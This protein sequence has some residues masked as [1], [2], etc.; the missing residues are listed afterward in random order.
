M[1]EDLT[2][3]SPGFE[4][5]IYF[6]GRGESKEPEDPKLFFQKMFPDKRHFLTRQ[7]HSDITLEADHSI[8][9][10]YYREADGIYTLDCSIALS[11]RAADCVPIVY[12]STQSSLTG[13]L[14]SGWR[15]FEKKALT[16]AMQ[17]IKGEGL[18]KT[19]DDI[20]FVV[21][22]HIHADNYEVGEDVYSRFDPI[23]LHPHSSNPEKRL[24]DQKRLLLQEFAEMG[25]CPR[26]VLWMNEDTYSSTQFF[27]H[28]KGDTERNYL[29]VRCTA[30]NEQKE[31]S[32][33]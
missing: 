5:T 17:K 32:K 6:I 26:S 31:S 16:K 12:Y 7:I 27:S 8:D 3:H 18:F 4:R 28:R 25:V 22:P 13:V 23:F 24:L 30:A 29:A 21:G 11:V 20:I 19:I 33:N 1:H 2:L 9:G 15:G 14:H 10:D